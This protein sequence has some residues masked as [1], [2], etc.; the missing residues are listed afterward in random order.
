MSFLVDF[1]SSILSLILAPID[2]AIKTFLPSSSGV[3]SSI[4]YLFDTIM[5][6]ISWVISLTG[7][8]TLTLTLIIDYAIFRFSVPLLIYPIKLII[9]WYNYFKG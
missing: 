9:S 5:S 3:L 6:C 2:I 8:N 4:G 7:I 1:M